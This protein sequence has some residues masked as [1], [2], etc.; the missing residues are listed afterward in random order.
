M[1]LNIGDY[2]EKLKNNLVTMAVVFFIIA[3]IMPGL[4]VWLYT[5][6]YPNDINGIM[7]VD[8]V[9][10][11]ADFLA[12]TMTPFLTIA[13]FF[14]L[15]KGYFMQ[16]EE[17]AQT[18]EEMKKSAEALDQQRKVMEEE[19]ILSE[20]QKEFETF[21]KLLERWEPL[22]DN[23]KFILPRFQIDILTGDILCECRETEEVN[24]RKFYEILTHIFFDTSNGIILWS[25][26][27][28]I[29][30][31]SF[32]VS[33]M[34]ILADNVITARAFN[35]FAKLYLVLKYIDGMKSMNM[36]NLALNNLKMALTPYE[37]YIFSYAV[38]ELD[39]HILDTDDKDF[40]NLVKKYSDI[41]FL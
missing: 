7:G 30:F 5:A 22:G 27:E 24:L 38:I 17:L 34:K 9:G 8:N 2:M 12:G 15:L 23:I 13:A 14:L 41:L 18:R 35:Y 11:T 21:I 16:K 40:K 19:K 36:K 25:D 1:K 29:K 31:E 20:S 33:N 26:L 39:M 28:K 3:I 32:H 37:R 10:S 6:S 4:T